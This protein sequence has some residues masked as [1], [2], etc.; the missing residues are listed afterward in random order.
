MNSTNKCVFLGAGELS[1]DLYVSLH[2]NFL[3]LWHSF[4]IFF[5]HDICWIRRTRR[6]SYTQKYKNGVKRIHIFYSFPK[7]PYKKK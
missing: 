5:L 2:N 1:K 3:N 6:H 4:Y 7:L